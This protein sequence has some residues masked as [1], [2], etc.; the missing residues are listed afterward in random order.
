[1]AEIKNRSR[2]TFS[3]TAGWTMGWTLMALS[4]SRL[5]SFAALSELPVIA[6]T[7]AKPY[8]VPTLIPLSF[9]ILR[10]I[11]PFSCKRATRSGSLSMILS[12]ASD[13]AASGGAMPTL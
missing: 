3:S 5:D 4:K 11:R 1:M 8:E 6:G 10:N 12:A 9:A 13:A 7:M 2:A